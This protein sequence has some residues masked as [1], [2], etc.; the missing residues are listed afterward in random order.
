MSLEERDDLEPVFIAGS[1]AEAEFVE[2]LLDSEGIDYS[3]SPE[4][5]MKMIGGVCLQGLLFEVIP[6]QAGY[7]RNLIAQRGLARGVI[8]DP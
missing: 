4:P 6:G 2:K 3:L 7:C 5:Y 1:V 8:H